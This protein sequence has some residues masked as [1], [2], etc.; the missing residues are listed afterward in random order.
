LLFAGPAPCPFT[1]RQVT[2]VKDGTGPLPGLV[3]AHLDRPLPPVWARRTRYRLFD[4]PIL[5]S[6]VFLPDL[7]AATGR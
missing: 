5:V 1:R 4:A 6:E 2:R 7:I 3:A